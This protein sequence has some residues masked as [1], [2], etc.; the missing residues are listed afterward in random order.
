MPSHINTTDKMFFENTNLSPEK[1]V[2][3]VTDSLKGGDDGELYLEYTQSEFFSWDD[4]RLK[5]CTYDTDNGFGLRSIA[6]DKFGFAHS[7]ELSDAA[8]LRAGD[9]VKSVLTGYE[10]IMG[11][12]PR[13]TNSQLYSDDNPLNSKTFEAKLKLL[14]DIDTFARAKDSRV[15][16]VTIN[17]SGSWR[18]MQIIRSGGFKVADIMPS[19]RMVVVVYVEDAN[20]KMESG[21]HAP[22]GHHDY[23]RFFEEKFWKNAVD[24]AYRQACVKLEA[25]P[26]P[27]GEMQIVLGPGD[28]GILIH[29]A[30]GH[31]LES[32]S[33]RKGTAAFAGLIGQQ[34]A[35]KGVTVVDD[36]TI[37]ESWGSITVDDEGTPSQ[38]NVLIEDGILVGYMQ[39]KMNAR[40][41]GMEPT[42]NGRR[43]GYS[44]SPLPRMTNTFMLGGEHEPEEIIS[45]VKNGIYA[46][47]FGSGMVDSTSGDFVFDAHE[48]YLIENGKITTPVKG[49]TLTGNGAESL[50]HIKM[51]GNDLKV[52]D[53]A[54]L[55]GKDGQDVPVSEGLPTTLI[56]G[57][58]VGGTGES[59]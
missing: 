25:I 38:R 28:P 5:N 52:S 17:L 12:N 32:D 24:E 59:H 27:A 10:G 35:A 11:E 33:N 58:T 6:G 48:A 4:G 41:M 14:Q 46:A 49:A 51:I 23:D 9:T 44:D 40:L 31:G 53:S 43:E 57:L 37:S 20:G 13:G 2:K 8:L 56:E 42:G 30:V 15:K 22:G 21:Y 54:G 36:G 29:E 26:A 34:V 47:S 1:T 55:C 19:V 3:C 45:S 39:D 16:Q 50:K 7:S 18:A